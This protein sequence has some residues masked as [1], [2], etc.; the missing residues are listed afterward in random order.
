MWDTIPDN[1]RYDVVRG[2]L[3]SLPVG[4]GGGDEVCSGDMLTAVL[5]DS[6]TPSPGSGFW[7]VARG[8]SACGNGTF[9][10]RS[11]GAERVTTTCP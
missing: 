1:P 4:P 2:S 9:G 5:V 6:T 7:Y 3:A 10:F 8:E 11:N